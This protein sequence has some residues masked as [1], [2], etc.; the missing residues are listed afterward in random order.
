MHRPDVKP[1]SGT[2][3]YERCAR[4]SNTAAATRHW[5]TVRAGGCDQRQ[6]SE[7]GPG[8]TWSARKSGDRSCPQH[9]AQYGSCVRRTYR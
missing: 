2:S 7:A 9:A 3:S 4:S 8:V 5:F 1:L 6:A